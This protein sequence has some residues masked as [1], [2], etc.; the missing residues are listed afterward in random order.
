MI[1]CACNCYTFRPCFTATTKQG[2]S[3]FEEIGSSVEVLELEH[4]LEAQC[5]FVHETVREVGFKF[6]PQEIIPGMLFCAAERVLLEV[7]DPIDL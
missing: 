5:L 3:Q 6:P 2:P 1:F 4:D 7:Q